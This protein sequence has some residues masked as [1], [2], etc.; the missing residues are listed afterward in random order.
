MDKLKKGDVLTIIGIS[1]SWGA[2]TK[3]QVKATGENTADGKAIF[4][5]NKKGARKMFTLRNLDAKDKL[6]FADDVPFLIDSEEKPK[7]DGGMFVTQTI[8]M[9]ACINLVGDAEV[10]KDWILN[11]N[12]NRSFTSF[13]VVILKDGEKE[14]ALFP[15]VE[16]S[17]A[18]VA[19]IRNNVT[20]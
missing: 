13:D 18:V 10:I 20:A 19:R 7:S 6:I 11:K 17:H 12:L 15:E 1:D 3:N 4:K 9:N 5:E 14:T 16:T 2:T 8:H